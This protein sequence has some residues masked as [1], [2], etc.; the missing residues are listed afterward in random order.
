MID[1]SAHVD[2]L[3]S[4]YPALS[5]IFI[6]FG[7]PCLVCGEPFWGT[8]AELAKRHQV[9]IDELV[10]RLNEVRAEIDEKA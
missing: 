3:L 6:E 2:Q 1:S 9:S 7:L 5:K 10:K 4:K 8:I